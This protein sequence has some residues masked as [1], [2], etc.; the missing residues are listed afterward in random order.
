MRLTQSDRETIQ[1]VQHL[2][3]N[4][5]HN[6]TVKTLAKQFHLSE[7]KLRKGFLEIYQLN[8][9]E[10]HVRIRIERAKVL[11]EKTDFAIAYIAAQVGYDLRNL[12]RQFK[13]QIGMLP[14]EWRKN[15][16]S[17]ALTVDHV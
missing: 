11:L 15:K 1:R 7:S 2:L 17:S 9:H 16:G 5:Y 13:K 3:D 6:L 8:I 12:E 4:T 14:M 10:Y